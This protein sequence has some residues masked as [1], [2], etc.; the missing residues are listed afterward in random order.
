MSYVR[1][2]YL[3]KK[4]LTLKQASLILNGI[5]LL[6]VA[7]LYY[8]RFN[9][10]TTAESIPVSGP[11]MDS[12]IVF[13]NSDSLMDNYSLFEDMLES[14]GKKRDSLDKVLM[15]KGGLLE[16]EIKEYQERAA[17]MS[18]GER[19]LREE[20]L[21]KKQQALMDERDNL[22]DKLKEEEA[23]LTDSIH[24]DLMSYLKVFNKKHGYDFILGYS[25]GG[26]ILLASDSLDITKQ[27]VDGLNK[28]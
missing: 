3:W 11:A 27:V 23:E 1:L 4:L 26:G 18:A 6:A 22:L 13:V 25:R 17:G 7:Y 5:L 20:S 16:K 12:K 2:F 21:M 19:Q 10:G 24:S 15:N 28:K 8:L 14:M 9:D